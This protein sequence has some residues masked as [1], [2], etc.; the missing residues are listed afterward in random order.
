MQFI[1]GVLIIGA[2]LSVI[3]G[4]QIG[5]L[6]VIAVSWV[7]IVAVGLVFIGIGL[8]MFCPIPKTHVPY[9]QP[10]DGGP[11]VAISPIVPAPAPAPVV[12]APPVVKSVPVAPNSTPNSVNVNQGPPRPTIGVDLTVATPPE[13]IVQYMDTDMTGRNA[14][15]HGVGTILV[16]VKPNSPAE[17][18]GLQAGDVVLSVGVPGQTAY[19][20]TP[21]NSLPNEF[22][23]YGYNT[24]LSLRIYRMSARRDFNVLVQPD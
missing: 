5:A 19:W 24:P 9:A 20:I 21:S 23:H 6:F 13:T 12:Q 15:P 14:V 1:A 10:S 17:H 8:L 22:I 11:A 18:V 2:L 7:T 16:D 3:F 4:K